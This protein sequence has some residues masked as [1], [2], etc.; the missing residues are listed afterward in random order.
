MSTADDMGILEALKKTVPPPRTKAQLAAREEASPPL[1][2]TTNSRQPVSKFEFSLP[3]R[4][5]LGERRRCSFDIPI[6]VADDFHTVAVARGL[7]MRDVVERL[8]AAFI[9]QNRDFLPAARLS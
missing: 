3:T 7:Q 2:D 8:M 4:R 6:E 1:A 9:E 5:R